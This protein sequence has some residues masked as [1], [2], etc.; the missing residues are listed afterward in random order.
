MT[1]SVTQPVADAQDA[2]HAFPASS[3]ADARRFVELP[4][5]LYRES[6][7]WVPRLRRDEYRRLSR[8]H[9]PFLE[10]ADIALWLASERGRIVGRIAAINDRRHDETHGEAVT[11]FGFFEAE[12]AAAAK[13]LLAAAERHARDRRSDVVRGPANPSLNESAGLL[14]EGFAEDPFLLMPYNSPAY[15][16]FIEGAGYHKTKDLLA[17]HIDLEGQPAAR[18]ARVA[19]RVVKRAGFAIRPL[20]VAAFDR[21]LDAMQRIYREA[22]R[23]N[24]GFVA[25]TPAEIRR[26][27]RELRPLVD[28]ELV[29]FVERGGEPVAFAVSLP[30]LNQVL[31]RMHGRLWPWGFVHFLRRRAIID[32]ARLLLLGVLPEVRGLGLYALLIAES[33][34]RAA[35]RGY[36][37]AELSWT[38]EDN[39]AVNEGIA[40]AG[41]RPYKTYRLYEKRL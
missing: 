16:T 12:S 37:R 30:D 31:K 3:R 26:L 14:V 39:D 36:R 5:A 4:Y 7:H 23:D 15:Q 13:A 24:W 32:Q 25:P 18:I 9:N 41:G 1:E 28:P 27:A 8:R 19:D 29:L 33:Y 38:L 11:W 40:A 35:A 34:R 10:H 6:A 20:E 17:W 22:W 21:D 2:V